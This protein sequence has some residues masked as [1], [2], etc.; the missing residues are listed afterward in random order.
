[1]PGPNNAAWQ[2]YRHSREAWQA[3]YEDCKAARQLIDIEEYI[4]LD[5]AAGRPLI[6]ILMQ[7]A[8][9]GLR[10]RL[11]IDSAGSFSAAHSPELLQ[12]LRSAGILLKV[13]NPIE[14]RRLNR[15]FAWLFRDHR[16]IIVIDN[17]VAHIGGVCFQANMAAWRD[18]QIR[19]TGPILGEFKR[20]FE[21]MWIKGPTGQ[22]A[23]FK[24]GAVAPDGF[25]I[26]I[27][28][29]RFRQRYFYHE[30]LNR[31]R[32]ASDRVW[33]TTP[34][35]IPNYRFYRALRRAARRG[36]DVRMI[37]ADKSDH[38]I[39]DRA[40]DFHIG[41]ALQN[42][43]AVHRYLPALLHAKT[44]VI[45]DWATVGSCNIDNLSF[46]FNH[47]ANLAGTNREFVGAVAAMFEEDLAHTREI[48]P[49][50]WQHRPWTAKVLEA[51]TW[52][53]HRV[54]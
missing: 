26:L 36:A 22:Y 24:R 29:P 40:S 20:T 25:Q 46:V 35:F 32:E 17:E 44:A 48:R 2:I 37:V 41:P 51:L 39:V 38:N 21:E 31:I 47:E 9:Q 3:V 19:I 45:D 43:V 34:Y 10:V 5:D 14:P 49:L 16:K 33:I 12:E 52:P 27:N 7:K 15:A 11:L 53:L 30:L 42:G 13:F 8:R 6:D 54:L 1:M 4:I 50:E 23:R 28:A 18:T